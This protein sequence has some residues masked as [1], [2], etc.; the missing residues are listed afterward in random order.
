MQIIQT[1]HTITYAADSG[2][3]RLTIDGDVFR[4][5]PQVGGWEYASGGN[6]DTLAALIV[7]A[8]ADALAR[9]LNWSGT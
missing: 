3:W 2:D 9:G 8:K 6:L 5:E 4:I 1:L 7:A